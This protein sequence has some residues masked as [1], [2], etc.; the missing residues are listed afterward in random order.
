MEDSSF[1]LQPVTG[2][3]LKWSFAFNNDSSGVNFNPSTTIS[4]FPVYAST[5]QENYFLA[6]TAPA[7]SCTYAGNPLQ[8]SCS[9]S[10]SPYAPLPGGK[11]YY[12]LVQAQGQPMI[13]NHISNNVE[14][15]IP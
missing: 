13:T 4:G 12:L 3:T 10:L 11:T 5:D 8:A 9:V 14:K 2:T 6:G 1:T 15:Y 7:N